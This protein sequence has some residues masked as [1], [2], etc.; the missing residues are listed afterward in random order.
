MKELTDVAALL[1]QNKLF[2]DGLNKIK[3]GLHL[4]KSLHS[5]VSTRRDGEYSWEI[6][7][8]PDNDFSTKEEFL[9]WLHRKPSNTSTSEKKNGVEWWYCTGYDR[10]YNHVIL[11]YRKTGA[12][13]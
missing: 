1:A 10:K 6:H 8:R 3:S 5:N 4:V 11:N 7:Y 12:V 2:K 9:T 13:A